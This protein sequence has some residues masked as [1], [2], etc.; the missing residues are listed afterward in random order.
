MVEEFEIKKNQKVHF[1]NAFGHLFK[2]TVININEYREPSMR[3]SLQVDGIEDIVF[4][5]LKNIKL[6]EEK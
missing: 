2:A 4:T 5:S 3:V 6:M 1:V